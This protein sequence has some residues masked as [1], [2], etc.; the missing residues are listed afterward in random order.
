MYRVIQR[1]HGFL[2][3]QLSNLVCFLFN[4]YG[5]ALPGI[6]KVT[7]WTSLISFAVILI[8]VPATADTHQPAKF[9]FATFINQTGWKQNGIAFIVGLINTNWSFA[10]LDCATHLAEEVHRPERMVPIAIMGTV[11]IGFIT[12]WF[13]SMAMFFSV[14]GDWSEIVVTPTGV[15]ILEL[16]YR[17]LRN[18]AGAVFLEVMIIATGLGC[19]VASH[20]WQSRLCWSFARDRGV[21]G[22]KWLSKVH[23]GLDVPVN[24][25]IVSCLIV[26]LVGC[27][28]LATGTA[29]NS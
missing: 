16:F 19:L 5:R 14:V 28:Y 3:Y 11:A 20:T 17:A 29:F 15:P 26:A 8:T 6:A 24:A 1:W 13:F 4:C 7:L 2:V 21:P 12:S 22:H 27:L 9:V 23:P 18:K 10:C 25:H